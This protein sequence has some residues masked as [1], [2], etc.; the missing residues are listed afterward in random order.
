MAFLR[1]N[2]IEVKNCEELQIRDRNKV[3]KIG[4]LY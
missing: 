1:E 4:V 2:E 3:F